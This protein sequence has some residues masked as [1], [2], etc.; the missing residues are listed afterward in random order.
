MA[1]VKNV[2]DKYPSGQSW[3][4]SPTHKKGINYHYDSGEDY[5]FGTGNRN[6]TLIINDQSRNYR[7]STSPG[8][9]TFVNPT[10]PWTSDS[11]CMW[12]VDKVEFADKTIRISRNI[13]IGGQDD[14]P[15]KSYPPHTS[16]TDEQLS[17]LG[18]DKITLGKPNSNW[19]F[20][21]YRGGDDTITGQKSMK[22]NIVIN[23]KSSEFDVNETSSAVTYVNSNNIWSSDQLTLRNIDAIS[24]TDQVLFLKPYKVH[25]NKPKGKTLNGTQKKDRLT[26]TNGDD[27]INGYGGQDKIKGQGGEDTINPGNHTKGKP[28]TVWGGSGKD[29]FIINNKS[30]AVIKDFNIDEDILDLNLKGWEWGNY[31]NAKGMTSI[32]N[33]EGYFVVQLKGNHDLNDA[34]I[35]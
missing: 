31:K 17:T 14:G 21:I 9:I 15:I 4:F 10:S 33:S 19:H 24:F 34:N 23:A 35:I 13:R 8:A 32:V 18:N 3:Y 6:D 5:F 27:V 22:E 2:F 1:K 11:I 26:G 25:E 30:W 16:F 20:Y 12:G 29:T 7:I 28:D